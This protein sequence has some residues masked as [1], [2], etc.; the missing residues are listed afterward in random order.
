[1]CAVS[2]GPDSAALAGA[3]CTG[4]THLGLLSLTLAHV[5]HGLRPT[6]VLDRRAAES[7]ASTL[8]LSLV[9]EEVQVGHEGGIE[10]GARKARYGALQRIAKARGCRFVV[11]A[12][13]RTDQAE[14]VLLRLLRGSGLKGLAAMAPVR[15]LGPGVLLAR[16]LLGLSR[17]KVHR[18]V[19]QRGLPT[20]EDPTNQETRFLR[21]ALRHE[22]WPALERLSPSL[23]VRLAALAEACREDEATLSALARAARVGLLSADGDGLVLPRRAVAALP[24]PVARRVLRDVLLR[25]RPRSSPSAVHLR[26][27]LALVRSSKGA[28]LHLP[29]DLRA[30]ARRGV[31]RLGPRPPRK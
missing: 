25:L 6:S 20:F 1:L 31:L 2:G 15:R 29:G 16:P 26:G 5:D 10:A 12:H 21:N 8:G 14:T 7:L 13:T 28:E 19:E 30:E 23:E 22:V 27:L 4:L 18:Y 17:R 9:V 11:V 24:E 3:L